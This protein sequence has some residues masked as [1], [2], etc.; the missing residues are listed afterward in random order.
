M[1]LIGLN[2][3]LE[4]LHNP[5]IGTLY[6]HQCCSS[7]SCVFLSSVTI[8]SL[9]KDKAFLTA[10]MGNWTNNWTRQFKDASREIEVAFEKTRALPLPFSKRDTN[11]C[12]TW[13]QDRAVCTHRTKAGVTG[14]PRDLVGVWS[15]FCNENSRGTEGLRDGN[16]QGWWEGLLEQEGR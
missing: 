2:H 9:G 8:Y 1:I 7:W 5:I 16:G 13:K 11:L 15:L 4:L 10:R 12:S 3:V 6:Q 14:C